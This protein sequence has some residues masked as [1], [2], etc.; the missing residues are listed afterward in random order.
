VRQFRMRLKGRLV[1]PYGMNEVHQ[2]APNRFV[3]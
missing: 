2:R 1:D 3:G